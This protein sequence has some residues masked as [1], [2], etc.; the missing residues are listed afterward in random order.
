[1][2]GLQPCWAKKKKTA[3]PLLMGDSLKTENARG[4]GVSYIIMW[5]H[6]SHVSDHWTQPSLYSMSW[7]TSLTYPLARHAL[8][9]GHQCAATLK[10]EDDFLLS[11]ITPVAFERRATVVL[12]CRVLWQYTTLQNYAA[13]M[14]IT[15]ICIMRFVQEHEKESSTTNI[16]YNVVEIQVCRAC[17]CWTTSQKCHKTAR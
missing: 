15:L 1:M 17:R 11:Q 13:L 5:K 8:F 4:R 3:L 12:S 14:M 10:T 7:G 2:G 6:F 9:G 16:L